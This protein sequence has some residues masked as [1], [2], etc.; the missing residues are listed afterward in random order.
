MSEP[1]LEDLFADL[2]RA[3][4]DESA[5]KERRL[6]VEAAILAR[7]AVK[8]DQG[9]VKLQGGPVKCTV[10]FKLGYS[11]NVEQI[12]GI[13]TE[14]ALPV[15][16]IEARYEFDERAYESLRQTDPELFAQVAAFVTTKPKKPA[17]ELK[18]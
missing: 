8:P 5:A 14:K 16:R 9:R 18:L 3:K 4:A 1:T 10:E 13:E 6:A 2:V 7:I 11:A 15:K 12:L 17:I